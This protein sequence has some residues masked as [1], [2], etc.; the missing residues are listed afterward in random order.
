M[1]NVVL[2]MDLEDWYHLDYFDNNLGSKN[3][4]MLDGVEIYC[5]LLKQHNIKSN[6]FVVG[7]IAK[8]IGPTLQKISKIGH[9]IGSHGWDHTRPN[10]LSKKQ[11]VDQI[12]NS[13]KILE[14]IIGVSVDGYRAPCFSMDREKLNMVI[15][16]GYMFDSSRIDFNY[17]PLYSSI[18]MSNFKM[19]EKNIFR[20][21]DFFE[22]Q[23]T[24]Y[25]I[26]G[27]TIPISGGGYLRILPWYFS[28]KMIDNYLKTE[29]FFVLYIHPFELSKNPN[30]PFPKD[31]KSIT[32]FR[33]SYGRKTVFKKLNSLIKLLK[34]HN[35][36]FV[37]FSSLRDKILERYS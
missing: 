4:S 14:D 5:D 23:V 20:I 31:I 30:P 3:F 17:H 13:K 22:F 29:D 25:N 27:K 36:S 21:K 24:T 2:S 16:A 26:F 10:M 11:F 12:I 18:D 33:F 28:R 34:I 6:F 15:D 19:L 32:K 1:K 9:E 35:Y 8:K 37:T 7:E